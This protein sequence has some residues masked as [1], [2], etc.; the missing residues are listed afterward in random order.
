MRDAGLRTA[1]IQACTVET[2]ATTG[3]PKPMGAGPWWGSYWGG[4]AG[5]RSGP[6]TGGPCDAQSFSRIMNGQHWSKV[7]G[8]CEGSVTPES[9]RRPICW[10]QSARPVG[11]VSLAY[12]LLDSFSPLKPRIPYGPLARVQMALTR[13]FAW[14][15]PPGGVQGGIKGRSDL[16]GSSRSHPG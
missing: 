9:N 2:M 16:K 15:C 12:L 5:G 14:D 1:W 3:L 13:T 8:C 4:A 7:Y 11:P 10:L 6:E